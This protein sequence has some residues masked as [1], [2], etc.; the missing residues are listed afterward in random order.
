MRTLVLALLLPASALA[1]DP[2]ATATANLRQVQQA[3]GRGTQLYR[4]QA[5]G[6]KFVPLGPDAVLYKDAA[7]H[8][9]VATHGIGPVWQ[10]ADGSGVF[11]TVRQSIPAADASTNIAT[12][13]LSAQPFG[14]A[15]GVL[16]PVTLVTRTD[17]KGGAAPS[18]GCDAGHI[19]TVAHVPYTA[20]YTFYA[21]K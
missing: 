8:E 10:W 1:Q 12:L 2:V 3:F 13:V 17:A 11:G 19:G 15:G 16:A 4:C 7:S 9:Q 21:A 6:T 14:T 20:V 18:G 5:A